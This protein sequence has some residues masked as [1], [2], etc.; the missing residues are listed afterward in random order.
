QNPMMQETTVSAFMR[1]RAFPPGSRAGE[2]VVRRQKRKAMVHRYQGASAEVAARATFRARALLAAAEP[3]RSAVG[4]EYAH[5][6][7]HRECF[8]GCCPV[9]AGQGCCQRLERPGRN[10][11]LR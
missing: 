8:R 9:P 11:E 2:R 5:S 1:S 7:P 6:S 10:T 4:G 3:R